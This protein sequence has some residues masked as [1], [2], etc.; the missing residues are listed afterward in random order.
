MQNTRLRSQNPRQQ[1][2]FRADR[3]ESNSS[4]KDL[5]ILVDTKSTI[6][7]QCS[8]MSKKAKIILGYFGKSVVA[9]QFREGGPSLL[10]SS[11]GP[12]LESWVELCTPLYRKDM[13]ILK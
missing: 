11:G 5:S 8:L 9:S 1:Y 7:Q 12:H 6:N 2:T 4:E 13:D 10:L 3:I